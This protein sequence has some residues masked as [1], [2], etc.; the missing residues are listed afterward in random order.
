MKVFLAVFPAHNPCL[1]LFDIDVWVKTSS[2][3][4]L[5]RLDLAPKVG[6]DIF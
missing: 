3:I 6:S 1:F 2:C 4:T 5:V